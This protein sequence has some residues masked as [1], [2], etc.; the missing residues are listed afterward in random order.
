MPKNPLKGFARRK[1]SGNVLDI[2]AEQPASSAQPVQG[3]SFRVLERPNGGIDR[4][5]SSQRPLSAMPFMT[6]RGKSTDD[7]ANMGTHAKNSSSSTLPSSFDQENELAQDELSFPSKGAQVNQHQPN[8]KFH[9]NASQATAGAP[10]PSF[11]SRASRAMSFGLRKK[12]ESPAGLAQV[13]E[14]ELE[15]VPAIPDHAAIRDRAETI[16]S[17]ASTAVPPRLEANLGDADFSS[18]F[19]MNMF[20]GLGDPKKDTPLPPPPRALG[21][22]VRSD[23]EPMFASRNVQRQ[24]LTPSPELEPKQPQRIARPQNF[25]HTKRYSWQSR[26]SV[27]GLMSPGV[28]SDFASPRESDFSQDTVKPSPGFPRFRPG[29]QAVPD[30]Y[31]SPGVESQPGTPDFM[32][33]TAIRQVNGHS[34]DEEVSQEEDDSRPASRIH[35]RLHG[36]SIS[37]PPQSYHGSTGSSDGA[38]YGRDSQTT[39]P[40]ANKLQPQIDGDGLFDISPAGP[41]SRAIP[42]PSQARSQSPPKRMTKAQFVEMQRAA[43]EDVKSETSDDSE[44]G[45]DDGDEEDRQAELTRQRRKQ[46]ANLAVYRQQMKKVSGG[47]PSELPSQADRPAI[48]RASLSAP[49]LQQGMPEGAVEEEDDDVPLGILQAHGFPNKNRPPTR[50]GSAPPTPGSQ[51]S[52]VG[53]PAMSGALPAFARRLPQDPYFGASL[54]NPMNRESLAF[55]GNLNGS[56]YG[57][58]PAVQPVHPGGLV[59]VIAGEE[60][61]KAARRASPNPNP[62][63]GGYGPIPLPSNMLQGPVMMPRSNSMMSV[64][65]PP[66]GGFMPPVSPMGMPGMMNPMGMDTQQQMIQMMQMQQHMMQSI[67]QMQAGQSPNMP[68]MSQSPSMNNGFLNPNGPQRPMPMAQAGPNAGRTMSM[69]QPPPQWNGNA[70]GHGR[71]N[72]MG[73]NARPLGYAGSVYNFNLSAPAPGYTPSIAPSERS[74]VAGHKP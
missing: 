70:D 47:N 38:S 7:L 25:G 26:T 62:V 43:P 11:S 27:D 59:G 44:D 21:G 8:H 24:G 69:M 18:D 1:S 61:A 6:S 37:H 68:P 10:H 30:R 13:P 53:E 3:S 40:R 64:V 63:T 72:T 45:Y 67:I 23:S 2:Q 57:G 65:Q 50:F 33:H 17:Y 54:V 35:P 48:G 15:P 39:T 74:N 36:T 56:A 49:L 20:E 52:V 29:Y 22:Y 73:S 41:A 42:P 58:A 9:Q 34:S 71:S 28:E 32:P 19:G 4:R 16:S 14:P 12:P 31:N 5:T 60:R 55:G 66:M 46:E 51:A